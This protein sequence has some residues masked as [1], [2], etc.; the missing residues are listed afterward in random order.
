MLPVVPRLGNRYD[1]VNVFVG[2]TR[3]V[4]IERCKRPKEGIVATN[5]GCIN[6]L[7]LNF[8]AFK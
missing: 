4:K 6:R 5:C 7:I 3:C 1:R 8:V 2:K